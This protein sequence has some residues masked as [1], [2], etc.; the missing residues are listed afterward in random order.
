MSDVRDKIARGTKTPSVRPLR[1]AADGLPGDNRP[2]IGARVICTVDNT[3]L[4]DYHEARRG[5]Y[6]TV[7]G[8]YGGVTPDSPISNVMV[9][10]DSAPEH[11]VRCAFSELAPA[12]SPLQAGCGRCEL[13]A[14]GWRAAVP[15]QARISIDSFAATE[16]TVSRGV[17]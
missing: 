2:K 11:E 15:S 13:R 7:V 4:I 10:W 6:G 16:W 12:Q 14:A 5:T 8:N 1:S 9:A 17:N 3:Y